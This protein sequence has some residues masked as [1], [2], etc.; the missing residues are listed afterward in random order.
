MIA[1]RGRV[2][3]GREFGR[4]VLKALERKQILGESIKVGD[5]ELQ[6]VLKSMSARRLSRQEWR[7][8]SSLTP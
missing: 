5:D 4:R 1:M 3:R 8:T 6:D 7:V 2:C